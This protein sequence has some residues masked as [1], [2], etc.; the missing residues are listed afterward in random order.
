MTTPWRNLMVPKSSCNTRPAVMLGACCQQ[1]WWNVWYRSNC[2]GVCIYTDSPW[3]E[4]YPGESPKEI[5]VYILRLRV[6]H[7]AN[8]L[9]GRR[10]TV[11]YAVVRA[12]SELCGGKRPPAPG[13]WNPN[14]LKRIQKSMSGRMRPWW[15]A[16]VPLGL[17][18]G[19][20]ASRG[21]STNLFIEFIDF[22]TLWVCFWNSV[23]VCSSLHIFVHAHC[24]LCYRS[25]HLCLA[26]QVLAPAAGR[27][28][29]PD[30]ALH[31]LVPHMIGKGSI[32][33]FLLYIWISRFLQQICGCLLRRLN[34]QM[35]ESRQLFWA[36][37]SCSCA[38]HLLVLVPP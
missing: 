21:M 38:A 35:S 20:P 19:W 4:D 8:L 16:L 11:F 6:P 12:K 32:F 9:G 13:V 24:T 29:S 26:S 15:Y 31:V 36:Y 23:S 7:L 25:I 27:T 34:A 37:Q 10:R 2:Q 22:D 33:P 18:N 5:E 3:R 17:T 30:R 14:P 1:A 28:E